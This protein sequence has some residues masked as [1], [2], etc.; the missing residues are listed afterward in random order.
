MKSQA[1]ARFIPPAILTIFPEPQAAT[2]LKL[3]GPGASDSRRFG[4]TS[5]AN[6]PYIR[7]TNFGRVLDP[8]T[9]LIS[10]SRTGPALPR[11]PCFIG[12]TV[13]SRRKLE[14]KIQDLPPAVTIY[15]R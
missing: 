4:L 11:R 13:D 10:H 7:D 8:V 12:E 9:S 3:R 15:Q 1:R 6:P 5:K 14:F 2:N